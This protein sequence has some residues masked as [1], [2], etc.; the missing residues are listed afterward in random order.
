MCSKLLVL[1]VM[2]SAAMLA[3]SAT[4]QDLA[5]RL[6]DQRTRR[7]TVAEIAASGNRWVPLLVSW[8]QTPPSGV[9]RYQLYLGLADTFAEMRT[10][11]AIPF[12]VKNLSLSRTAPA[13]FAPW[14]KRPVT[15][16]DTFPMAAAL[17]A[18]GREAADPLIRASRQAMLP[19]DR[20]I[21]I[22][23]IARMLH[24]NQDIPAARSY[25]SSALGQANQERYWA[26]EGLK[27]LNERSR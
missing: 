12:L 27:L 15:I 9:D 2:I 7:S 5:R 22:F 1:T 10:K 23:V 19:E 4:D 8:T 6:A 11:E 17:I 26:Q 25:L 24:R 14:L 18:I 3:L 16:E 20:V 13:D 21:A